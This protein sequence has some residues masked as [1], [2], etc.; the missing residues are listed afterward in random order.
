MEPKLKTDQKMLGVLEELQKRVFHHPDEFGTTQAD[1]EGMTIDSFW[2]V[3][4]SGRRY[5]REFV[6]EVLLERYS[7]PHEDIWETED[8]HCFEIA[9]DNYLLTD[10]LA[11]GSRITRRSTI[12]RCCDSVWKIVYHQGTIV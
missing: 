7:K 9:K 11:Q 3:G 6:I 10:T 1:I 12:W 2:E 4:A 8:F 5:S